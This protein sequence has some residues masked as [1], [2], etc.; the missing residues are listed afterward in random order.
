[1]CVYNPHVLEVLQIEI[2]TVFPKITEHTVQSF[3][4]D[5]LW[6]YEIC[7]LLEDSSFRR[8]KYLLNM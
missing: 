2:Q 3:S 7:L 1:V 5:V 6:Q 8:L 4:Q